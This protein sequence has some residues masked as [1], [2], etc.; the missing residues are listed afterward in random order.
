MGATLPV[1]VAELAAPSALDAT[2]EAADSALDAA[3]PA[4]EVAEAPA[5]EAAL[6]ALL[7]ALL[8]PEAADEA[9][10][11][12]EEAA[13]EAP[14]A[15]EEK[16]VV[17]PMVEV[18]VL[19]SEVMVV[20]IASV[21]M[22]T[23]APPAPPVPDPPFPPP[24]PDAPPEPPA[25]PAPPAR[26]L[27]PPAAEAAVPVGPAPRA[28]VAASAPPAVPVTN[29]QSVFAQRQS[30]DQSLTA[31]TVSVTEIE[32]RLIVGISRA[33]L[34]SAVT[35]AIAEVDVGAQA[36]F[37]TLGAIQL[38]KLALGGHAGDAVALLVVSAIEESSVEL[39]L[40]YIGQHC[41]VV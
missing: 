8:A 15:A 26:P 22:G 35:N 19:P 4:A 21:V 2:L 12:A 29:D 25:P 40:R 24:V 31:S 1:S 10:E 3:E 14:E 11:A 20:R 37:T 41:Q 23:P 38:I 34:E 27:V 18:I 13:P 16:M 6:P 33:R 5:E 32:R 28:E 30:G 7:A 36:L 17:L 9:P 39:D